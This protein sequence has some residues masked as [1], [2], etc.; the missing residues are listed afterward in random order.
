MRDGDVIGQRRPAEHAQ[1]DVRDHVPG[2]TLRLRDP[3]G[4]LEFDGVPL[5]VPEAERV[6]R[7]PLRLRDRQDGRRVQ[8]TAQQ[9]YCRLVRHDASCTHPTLAILSRAPLN[10]TDREAVSMQFFAE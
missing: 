1:V 4:G 6:G 5:A 8:S 10:C 9:N 7:V 2:D 3:L